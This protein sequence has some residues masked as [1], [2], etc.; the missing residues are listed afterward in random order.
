MSVKSFGLFSCINLVNS[1]Q[2]VFGKGQT[3][4]VT[5]AQ[6]H[7][8]SRSMTV[9]RNISN[10]APVFKGT[11]GKVNLEKSKMSTDKSPQWHF[12]LFLSCESA[13]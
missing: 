4:K 13:V 11:L 8:L 9:L 5:G 3:W 2:K 12:L 1:P 7:S 10:Y 6:V